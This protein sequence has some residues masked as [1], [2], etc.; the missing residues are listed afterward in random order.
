MPDKPK[1]TK[2]EFGTVTETKKTA[3]RQKKDDD[4]VYPE[5]T[6]RMEERIK[7]GETKKDKTPIE[8]LS[9]EDWINKGRPSGETPSA[10]AV[11]LGT[12]RVNNAVKAIKLIANLSGAGYKVSTEN[13]K[14]IIDSLNNAVSFVKNSFEKTAETETKI[15]LK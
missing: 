2:G 11:R 7:A 13:Q 8:I 12:K 10:K 4:V 1:R 9:K 5:Y 15:E 6:K 3:G 14:V